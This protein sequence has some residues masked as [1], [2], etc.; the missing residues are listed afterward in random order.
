MDRL[1]PR[2]CCA[3]AALGLA[4]SAAGASA[5]TPEAEVKAAYLYKLAS[6]VRWPGP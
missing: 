2:A 6:F 5:A 1:F 4:L 3:L